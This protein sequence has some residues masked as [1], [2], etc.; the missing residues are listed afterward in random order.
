GGGMAAASWA[1]MTRDGSSLSTY[2]LENA[3]SGGGGTNVV[4]V[5]LVDFRG[6]DTFG[7]IIVLGIAALAIYALLDGAL[8]GRVARRLSAWTPDLPVSV[9]RHPMIM[10]VATRVMLPLALLVGAYIF[11]R[12]H[13]QPGGG[14]I[15]ALVVS[16]ALIMQYMASGFGWAA[17]RVKVKYHAMIGGGVLVAAATGIAAMVMDRPFLTS[18]FAHVHLPVIGEFEL[19]SAMA[20]DTGVFLT[21]VGAVMLAL[22]NLSRMGRWTAH[23]PVNKTAMDVD[24][25]AVPNGESH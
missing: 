5:I 23:R 10:V 13:N 22:A 25:S 4:N 24:P 20:F 6:F 7:E 15:A 9:D 16:I 2:Y 19:A 21:V 14:F 17:Q 1:M 11:L 12:G 3:V 18:A 8:H